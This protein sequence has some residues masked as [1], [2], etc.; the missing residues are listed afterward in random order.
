MHD[1]AKRTTLRWGDDP[2]LR[3]ERF[4]WG[5]AVAYIFLASLLLR[6]LIAVNYLQSFDTEWNMLWAVQMAQREKTQSFGFLSAYTFVTELDYPPLYLYPL[7]LMG[8]LLLVPQI[9]GYPPFRMLVI[10]FLP[11]LADSLTGLV[12][13]RL[14]GRRFRLLGLFGLIAWSLNPATIVNCAFWGQTD[15]VMLFMTAALFLALSEKRLFASGLLFGLLCC[16][17]LQGLYLTPVVGMEVLGLCFG[18][19][20]IRDFRLKQINRKGLWRFAAFAGTVVWTFAA[21]YLPFMLGGMLNAGDGFTTP[22]QRFWLPLSVYGSGLDKYPFITMNGDNVY[23]LAGLNYRQDSQSFL[24][25]FSYALLGK[26]VLLAAMLTVAAVYLLCRRQSMW[27]AAYVFM[28]T[29]F[30]LTC[31]QHERYQIMVVLLL[32][33]VF[34][35]QADKRFFTLFWMQGAVIFFNQFRILSLAREG[36]GWW[37][38]YDRSIG[39]RTTETLPQLGAI[40]K[41]QGVWWTEHM[42][43][44]TMLNSFCNLLLLLAGLVMAA[45]F[46]C[47][48]RLSEPLTRRVREWVQ[49]CKAA[50]QRKN[51]GVVS[52]E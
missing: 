4:S 6:L 49:I 20:N 17:K 35:E 26:F 23:M 39:S 51:G 38:Y 27:M 15:C 52:G 2:F 9:G 31:R 30:M 12:L 10:K 48:E 41:E 43:A 24:P 25:G 28:N 19:V 22:S 44:A 13:Y 45:R 1:T 47:D 37:R 32:I 14:G 50:V 34:M 36:S 33:G 8:R 11:C 46:F 7:T 21:V 18:S 3:E 40:V 42:H 29:V 5:R 16:T